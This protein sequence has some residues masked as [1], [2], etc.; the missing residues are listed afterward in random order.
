MSTIMS[1]VNQRLVILLSL[2]DTAA[3]L[4]TKPLMRHGTL[5]TSAT[6]LVAK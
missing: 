4:Q 5:T 2:G 6:C 1:T 3:P